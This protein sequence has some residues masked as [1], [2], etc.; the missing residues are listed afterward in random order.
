VV[1][2]R[3]R[4][5][6]ARDGEEQSGVRLGFDSTVAQ[7]IRGGAWAARGRRWLEQLTTSV[8]TGIAVGTLGCGRDGAGQNVGAGVHGA[9]S[10][11]TR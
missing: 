1:A 8:R 7:M 2:T 11:A 5:E 10:A 4:V 3:R 9:G 6:R